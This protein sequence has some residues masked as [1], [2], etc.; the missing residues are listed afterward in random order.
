MSKYREASTIAQQA[1]EGVLT[2]LTPGRR[3]V[4][5]CTIGD[6]LIEKLVAPLYKSKKSMEKGVAFPTCVSVNSIVAH[7]SPLESED[8]TELANG[9]M[10]KMCVP[11][12]P[13]C[14]GHI[15]CCVL[16]AAAPGSI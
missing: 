16:A 4:D 5:I 2:Q 11:H 10:V 15:G 3:V 9:D 13:D 1:L 12:R 6:A 7:Y 14:R 8:K